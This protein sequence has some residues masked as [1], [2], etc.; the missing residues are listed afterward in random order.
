MSHGP[1]NDANEKKLINRLAH[2]SNTLQC[3]VVDAGSVSSL[4]LAT[5]GI[6]AFLNHREGRTMTFRVSDLM[7]QPFAAAAKKP[8]RIGRDRPPECGL[9]TKYTDC[10]A[11]SNLTDCTLC[12]NCT[13]CTCTQ[14]TATAMS[15][16][17]GM[18]DTGFCS[19][20]LTASRNLSLLQTALE[21]K[22]Q[23]YQPV[24]LAPSNPA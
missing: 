13:A 18:T 6:A 15:T 20:S 1:C 7:I 19:C 11:C 8:Q 4:G 3:R 24:V 2:N 5:Q 10:G 22:V 9:C 17:T 23:A 21:L 12:T 16:C 14:C